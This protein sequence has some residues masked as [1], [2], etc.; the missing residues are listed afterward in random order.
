VIAAHRQVIALRIRVIATLHFAH[1]PPIERCWITVLLIASNHAAL[2]ADALRHIE[3]KAI[4]LTRFQ[5][6]HGYQRP[7]LDLDLHQGFRNGRE[8]RALHQR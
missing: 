5:G 2:A 1:A 6:S 4:L 3:V 7:A 8:Q